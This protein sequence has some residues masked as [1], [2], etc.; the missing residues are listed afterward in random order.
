MNYK[1]FSKFKSNIAFITEKNEK[2]T[3]KNFIQDIKNNN[4]LGIKKNSLVFLISSQTYTFCCLY[5]Y[6]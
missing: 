2:K 5:Y 3:Y 4:D 1:I 6:L